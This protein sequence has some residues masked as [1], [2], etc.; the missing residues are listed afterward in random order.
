MD[1]RK[2]RELAFQIIQS[3]PVLWK[4]WNE[5][6]TESERTDMLIH[7]AYKIGREA[8]YD[9]G[10]EF[11]REAGYNACRDDMVNG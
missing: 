2:M 3:D 5:A 11:G 6:K 4:E 1:I 7:E 9:S 8:G 10:L